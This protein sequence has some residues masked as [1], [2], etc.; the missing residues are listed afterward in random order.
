MIPAGRNRGAIPRRF[1]T[2]PVLLVIWLLF[3]VAAPIT[4]AAA[5]ILDLGSGRRR[6]PTAR[7]VLTGVVYL[8]CETIGLVALGFSWL[9]TVR[10]PQRRASQAFAVQQWWAH[11]VLSA[12]ERLF[13]VTIEATGTDELEPPFVLIARHSSIVDNLLPAR[14]I[15]R[16]S[17]AHVRYVMKQ[18]L[19]VDPCLDVA[20]NRL[21]NL[22][23]DRSDGASAEGIEALR[24]LAATMSEREAVLIYP[25]GTRFTPKRLEVAMERLR[26]GGGR[27][28]ELGGRLRSVLP[29][30]PAGVHA[31]L[32][33]TPAD[34]VVMAHHGLDGLTRVKDI[35]RGGLTG[36]VVSVRFWRIRRA[37]IP[38]DKTDQAEWL[39][40]V[41]N[42]VDEWVTAR[43]TAGAS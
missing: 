24:L 41:W 19:L 36:T 40:R 13:G 8:W 33:G 20:G 2:I 34:V 39:Y 23:V 30:K 6:L 10:S 25:E 21:P 28:A 3:T 9:I 1:K 42:E 16:A 15:S 7:L 22:F 38:A 43:A 35:L 29:P 14:L 27:L 31:L 17:G 37:D 18:E 12:V 4:L 26:R 11:V 32:S 5:L